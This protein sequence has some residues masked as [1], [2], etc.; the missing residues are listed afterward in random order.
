MPR[1]RLPCARARICH[2]AAQDH[3]CDRVA[4]SA[5]LLEPAGARGR[6]AVDA[7]NEGDAMERS[8]I[9]SLTLFV[10]A[11]TVPA[12]ALATV[13]RTF[14]ASN[15]IDANP[16]SVTLPCRT[17]AAALLQT[18]TGGEIIVL[19]SAGYGPVTVNKAVSIITPA[20]VYAGITNGA[21]DGI[22]VNAPG[23]AVVLRGLDINGLG[24]SNG[25]G[26][27]HQAA[28][29]LTIDR[30]TIS[31]FAATSAVA[32]GI[33]IETGPVTISNTSV[34][35]NA[36]GGIVIHGT[37]G[38]N[39]L[40]A[41]I[42]DSHVEG[43]GAGYGAAN[44]AG[45]AVVSGALVT[46]R[47]TVATGNFRGF[48]VCGAGLAEPL[49]AVL[50]VENSFA[51]RNVVGLFVAPNVVACAMRASSSTIT[52]NTLFGIEQQAGNVVTS[53]GNNFVYSNNSGET[54]GL[55]V[56]PK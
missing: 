14:V 6:G 48:S 16:C 31:G 29:T 47:N 37:D 52:D 23:A 49:G 17:F 36:R 39:Y 34:S 7:T 33:R 12:A 20:G 54:F 55:S 43:N 2:R 10:A 30:C 44:D 53:L 9:R 41:T 15:G 40:R 38:V 25:S 56:T 42:V 32:A 46:V 3:R 8:V 21:G 28:A 50:S 35:R 45:I 18:N 5:R 24:T 1:H 11:M 51:H 26:I 4:T 13:Q 27:L 22:V 19:D